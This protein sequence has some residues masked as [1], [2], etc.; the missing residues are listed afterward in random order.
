MADSASYTSSA[1]SPKSVLS[2]SAS[3]GGD[4]RTGFTLRSDVSAEGADASAGAGVSSGHIHFVLSPNTAL[5]LTADLYAG[6]SVSPGLATDL[7]YSDVRVYVF[8]DV[9]ETNSYNYGIWLSLGY[10]PGENAEGF[11]TRHIDEMIENRSDHPTTNMLTFSS[12]VTADSISPVPKPGPF[13]MVLIGLS[14]I[15]AV[16]RKQLM[17]N[18][19]G[20]SGSATAL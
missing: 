2:A 7:S 3:S 9:P 19:S 4:L 20:V 16:R 12:F 14:A 18:A 13:S 10:S 17:I 1:F 5:R 8:R 11:A 6:A 15:T